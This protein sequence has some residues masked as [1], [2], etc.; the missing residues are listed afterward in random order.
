MKG[1]LENPSF[2]ARFKY[3][4]SMSTSFNLVLTNFKKD[5]ASYSFSPL[6]FFLAL[7][8]ALKK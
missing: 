7:T 6:Y 1:F 4:G 2:T 5:A 3:L 8:A